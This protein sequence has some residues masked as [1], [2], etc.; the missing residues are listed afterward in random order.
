MV[1]NADQCEAL[2]GTQFGAVWPTQV[3]RCLVVQVVMGAMRCL[4][5]IGL[6]WLLL[7][8]LCFRSNHFVEAT[9]SAVEMIA[10]MMRA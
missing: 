9:R 8:R 10:D 2:E 5:M 1:V 7:P 3:K 6:S 4:R